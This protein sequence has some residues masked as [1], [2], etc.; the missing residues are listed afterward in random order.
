M[1]RSSSRPSR[2]GILYDDPDLTI[3]D[4]PA[5]VTSISERWDPNLPTAIDLLWA[6]WKKR[7]PDAP[8]P[9]VVHRLDKDTSGLLAFAR[10]RDAQVAMREQFRVRTV[11]KRYLALTAGIPNPPDG[12]IEIEI[13][14]DP[15]N[16]GRVRTIKKGGKACFTEYRTLAVHGWYAW[17]ELHPRTG[18]THQLRISLREVSAPIV[19]DPFYGD[20]LPVFLSKVKRNYHVGRGQT[21][22]PILGRLGLHAASLTFDHPSTG[23]RTTVLAPLPKDLRTTLRQ[24]ERWS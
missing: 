12:Q 21:E 22:R 11:E 8:R 17:V 9:H 14:S 20:G 23:V 24:L 1:T 16:P 7:D 15:S 6:E 18:R 4:K 10:H 13:E 3:I 5:G 2:I 19:A